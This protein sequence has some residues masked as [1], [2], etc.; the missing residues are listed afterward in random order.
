MVSLTGAGKYPFLR[1]SQP[2][3][4]LGEGTVGSAQEGSFT[5]SN[6]SLVNANY[7]VARVDQEHDHVFTMT[8][9]SGLLL[10]GASET[11]KVAFVPGT[12]G[13][14]SS[15]MWRITTPGGVAT[16]V[17]L[18]GLVRALTDPAS[19][20]LHVRRCDWLGRT[21]HMQSC[22]CHV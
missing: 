12:P 15:E 4:D 21:D 8:P 1:V 9:T 17:T 14:F 16:T 3:V 6:Q 7:C 5:L 22:A 20:H 11:V 18:R 10:P 2:V 13:V 19:L